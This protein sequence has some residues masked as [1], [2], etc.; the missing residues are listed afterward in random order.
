M[1]LVWYASK[2][3]I[4]E[5]GSCVKNISFAFRR[6]GH[7]LASQFGICTLRNFNTGFAPADRLIPC[8]G[9]FRYLFV[10]VHP[11]S[12]LLCNCRNGKWKLLPLKG[13]IGNR[14][15][16]KFDCIIILYLSLSPWTFKFPIY[17]PNICRFIVLFAD[18]Q[19]FST[20]VSY[21]N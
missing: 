19:S 21:F 1:S 15:C 2:R 14:D 11:F 16:E 10:L 5:P 4:N 12:A 20:T 7:P 3:S 9:H 18:V 6:S 13:E 17:D 8:F